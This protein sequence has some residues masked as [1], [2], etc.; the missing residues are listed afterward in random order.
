MNIIHIV[1]ELGPEPWMW[2]LGYFLAIWRVFDVYK[3]GTVYPN[4]GLR[5]RLILNRV[6]KRSKRK[7]GNTEIW[8]GRAKRVKLCTRL[9]NSRMKMERPTKVTSL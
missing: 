1:F 9:I 5:S 3:T 8:V 6:T 2:L 7:R 4:Q